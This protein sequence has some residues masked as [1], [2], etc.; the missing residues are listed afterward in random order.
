MIKNER[1]ERV[2]DT[3]VKADDPSLQISSENK[4]I[5]DFSVNCAPSLDQVK[6]Y[7]VKL[8]KGTTIVGYHIQ[9]KLDDL[10]LYMD[11][12]HDKDSL[13]ERLYDCSKMFNEDPNTG[14]QWKLTTLCK[15]FLNLTYKKPSK[16]YA[17]SKTNSIN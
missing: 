4:K 5:R 13:Y 14:Q 8:F 15:D 7:L 11:V 1:G 2:L 9:M 16:H 10:E 6:E 3:L 12:T 17:V